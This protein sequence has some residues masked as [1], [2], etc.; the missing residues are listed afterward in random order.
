MEEHWFAKV[1]CVCNFC[2]FFGDLLDALKSDYG[3]INEKHEV[4]RIIYHFSEVCTAVLCN[5][6]DFFLLSGICWM[7]ERSSC[8]PSEY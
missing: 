1:F 8:S 7:K 5:L 2:L 4:I 3:V 6:Q